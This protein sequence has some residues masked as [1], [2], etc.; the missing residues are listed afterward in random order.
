MRSMPPRSAP[1]DLSWISSRESCPCDRWLA[2]PPQHGSFL[3]PRGGRS[4]ILHLPCRERPARA[5]VAAVHPSVRGGD[6]QVPP[7]GGASSSSV[8]ERGLCSPPNRSHGLRGQFGRLCGCD[9]GVM[10][11]RRDTRLRMAAAAFVIPVVDLGIA[12]RLFDR[13]RGGTATETRAPASVLAAEPG[14]IT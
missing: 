1:L 12:F 13:R 7:H 4:T 11:P 10:A 5:R 9:L 8:L 3:S 2:R 14:W 6:E